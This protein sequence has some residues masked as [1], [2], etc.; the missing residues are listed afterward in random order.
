MK[1]KFL[2]VLSALAL[3]I[4][5]A[6]PAFAETKGEEYKIRFK[7]NY[8]VTNNATRNIDANGTTVFLNSSNNSYSTILD[9]KVTV[10]N[11]NYQYT[12]QSPNGNRKVAYSFTGI[13]PKSTKSLLYEAIVKTNTI[14]Y[15]LT[16]ASVQSGYPSSVA[17]YVQPSDKVQSTDTKIVAKA[18]E[19][20]S[21]LPAEQQGNP[22][23]I[24]EST[25]KFVQLNMKYTYDNRARNKGAVFALQNLVGNCEDYSSLMTA[26]L[27]A[28]DI[29]AR[30]VT[31]YRIKPS[32]I[33]IN[34]MNLLSS[35]N[36]TKHMWVEAYVEGYGWV[37][38]DPTV[39]SGSTGS[40]KVTDTNGT[41]FSVTAYLPLKTA[42]MDTFAKLEQLYI[43]D[44]IELPSIAHTM[45]TTGSP[46]A[47][48]VTFTAKRTA[49]NTFAE[50]Q[51]EI[52]ANLPQKVGIQI[53]GS[54]AYSLN[55]AP[56]KAKYLLS[57]RTT[58]DATDVTW[59]SDNTD[60]ATIDATTG[61]IKFTGKA[62][63][64]NFI[65]KG[66]ILQSQVTSTVTKSLQVPEKVMFN[67]NG[68]T[69]TANLVYNSGVKVPTTVTWS[70][71]N[72]NVATIDQTGKITY[73][74][75]TGSFT[76]TAK[77]E[78]GTT[79]NINSSVSANLV[80]SGNFN[81][82]PTPVQLNTDLVYNSGV[83]TKPPVTWKSSNT[84]VATISSDGV[85]TYTG[86]TGSTVIE[87]VA[88]GF[89][90][91]KT[92]NVSTTFLIKGNLAYS[93][94]P[95]KLTSDL[96]YS[97]GYRPNL[98]VKWNSLNP[99]IATVSADGTVTFTGKT[100]KL[101]IEA[102]A[103][104]FKTSKTIT[105]SASLVMKGNLA[106]ST[107]PVN[108]STELVY[109]SGVKANPSVTWTSSNTNVATV[110]DNGVVTFTGK[111]GSVTITAISGTFKAVKTLSVS[112]NLVMKGNLAY[113]PTPVALST[114]LVY[115]SGV[116]LNPS[117]TWKSSNTDVATVSSSGVVTFTGKTGNT[118]IEAVAGDFVSKRSVTV[119]ATVAIKGTLVYGTVPV[120][121]T[122]DFYYSTG[123]RP[124]NTE[125][126]WN[127]TNPAVA[128][129]SSTGL[130][131]FTGIPGTTSIEAIVG[132][133]N[134]KGVKSVSVTGSLV[135]KENPVFSTS[136]TQLTTEFT[137]ANK[138]KVSPKVT[139]KSTNPNVATVSETGVLTFTGQ[140]GSTT[141]EAAFG[142]VIT[143]KT[144]T[145][146]GSMVIK[147]NISYSTTPVKLTAELLYNTGLRVNPPVTWTSSNSK[148]AT[149]SSDGTVTFTGN[150]GSTTIT[151][152]YGSLRVSKSVVVSG[153]L[154]IKEN[155]A[156]STAPIQ[157]NTELT[158]NNGV[159]VSPKATWKS[160]NLTVA[161]VS[162]D[163]VLTF[164][165]S[166]GS[167]T[168]TATY[169]GL[170]VSK[171]V[172]VSGTM[173]IKE[174]LAFSTSPI[175]LTPEI[176][177]TNGV[178]V[179]PKVTWTSSNPNV[180][181]VS[182]DGKVTFTGYT[183]SAV[184]TAT[185]GNLKVSK[186]VTV[187]GTLGF[188]EAAKYSPT[189]YQIIAQMKYSNGV[190]TN[191][192][193]V[194]TSTNT[195]IATI[196]KDGNITF[197]GKAGSFYIQ[198]KFGTLTYRQ[199]LTVPVIK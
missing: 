198:A 66:G 140:T 52:E 98:P 7:G 29:P 84:N 154:S 137:Y 194:W 179:N 72:T 197:T 190:I 70:S 116:K 176:L 36:Y 161:S 192:S 147:E 40:V 31:G 181:I 193:V 113:S 16:P 10:E 78:D 159:K 64:V 138:T 80:M 67:P 174:T 142:N 171:S 129:V 124:S 134:A 61:Q 20:K 12:E 68:Q 14:D 47:F 45:S 48:N 74:G 112:A 33:S 136:P 15:E 182:A 163:G 199:Y 85:I 108:L 34:E 187:S 19:L 11:N 155:P 99:D 26:L 158:Y 117:V 110:S 37:A 172:S 148:V 185:Y 59:S 8:S 21:A 100:G 189:P 44:T 135:I 175:Q 93:T 150:V 96:Y 123:Y 103:G 101:T 196:D 102:V 91:T 51:K 90:T 3:L 82:S 5:F 58:V 23:Y 38:F 153:K 63:K 54:V 191:P 118:I 162:A 57:N 122:S 97:T 2:S 1:T 173:T 195:T 144:V 86:K 145:V 125:V 43:K 111:T 141:I 156:Y 55:P 77:T 87:A 56:L 71:S 121:L 22:Y 166:T 157:L 183:G 75:K 177:Y 131:T 6:S 165:G 139:W 109:N 53:S 18:Q 143:R 149:V 128:T 35:S 17:S 81:Y 60:V 41:V 25:F 42:Y 28:N 151:A 169:G 186:S 92:I 127:S 180:A 120:Q 95:V 24:L 83:K 79:L 115:N 65:A 88:E 49:H 27:R 132:S 184:I 152:T 106:Y 114:E 13:A 4:V 32:S 46:A 107:T 133:A 119:S 160:S 167:T 104:D 9:E 39:S 188:K 126:K 146:S 62:G 130:V 69:L 76:I 89:K 178:R 50:E 30:T 105:V 164:T 73:T 94:T 170:T 168:I